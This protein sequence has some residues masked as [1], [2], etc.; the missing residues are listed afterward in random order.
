MI[1]V[2]NLFFLFVFLLTVADV[3]GQLVQ[4]SL[5]QRVLNSE[6]VFEGKVIGQS[7]SWDESRR[8]IYT[9]NLVS[10]YKVFKGEL[11]SSI[12]EVITIGGTVGNE[13]EEVSYGL[14]LDEGAIGV[15]TCIPSTVKVPKTSKTQLRAYS[16]IQGFIHYDLEAGVAKDVFKVYPDI[17]KDIYLQ[18]EKITHVK[19]KILNKADFKLN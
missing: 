4:L 3:K 13:R 1:R 11:K 17:S 12:V 15:F 5:E 2:R 8:H 6:V 10:V 19:Y 9:T 14:N 18:L 7:A 16:E